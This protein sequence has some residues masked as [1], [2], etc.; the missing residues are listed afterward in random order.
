M[1]KNTMY[2]KH[3][4]NVEKKRASSR[5][6]SAYAVQAVIRF[7]SVWTL[8]CSGKDLKHSMPLPLPLP[9]TF[10]LVSVY[11]TEAYEMK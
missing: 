3:K 11:T 10:M 6:D 7:V 4:I 5:V 2:V 8:L 1:I 9:F